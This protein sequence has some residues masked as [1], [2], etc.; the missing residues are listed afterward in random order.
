MDGKHVHPSA[1]SNHQ[2]WRNG[3]ELPGQNLEAADP[4]LA[5]VV[6]AVVLVPVPVTVSLTVFLTESLP[7]RF[8]P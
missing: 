4:V 8:D 2:L 6:A 1:F 3:F 7:L 5:T